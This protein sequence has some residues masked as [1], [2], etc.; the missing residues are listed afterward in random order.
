MVTETTT[1]E[2]QRSEDTETVTEE[3]QRSKMQSQP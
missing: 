3:P 2:S 1:E